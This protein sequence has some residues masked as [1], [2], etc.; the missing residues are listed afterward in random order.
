MSL[1]KKKDKCRKRTLDLMKN[2]RR[3]IMQETLDYLKLI[4]E[5]ASKQQVA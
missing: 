2:E 5:K 1:F 4:N 3:K